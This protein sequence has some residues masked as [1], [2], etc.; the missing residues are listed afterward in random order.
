M[1]FCELVSAFGRSQPDIIRDV[2]KSEQWSDKYLRIYESFNDLVEQQE[3]NILDAPVPVE[4]SRE[5]AAR[6]PIA[7][8]LNGNV[9][10]EAT[11]T[12]ISKTSTL[13]ALEVH[14]RFGGAAIEEIGEYGS[15]VVSVELA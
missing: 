2:L 4:L 7:Y 6:F 12:S 5:I 10:R 3:R 13:T 1:K 14:D 11:A 15:V 9:L 8:E